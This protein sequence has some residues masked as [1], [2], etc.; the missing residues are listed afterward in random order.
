MD[1]IE[2]NPKKMWRFLKTTIKKMVYVYDSDL[3]LLVFDKINTSVP[4]ANGPTIGSRVF[5]GFSFARWAINL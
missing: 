3:G 1:S 2:G 5:I 4:R